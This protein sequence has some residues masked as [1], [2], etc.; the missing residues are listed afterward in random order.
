MAIVQ[1][2]KAEREGSKLF[3]VFSAW[4]GKGKTYTAVQFGYGLAGYDASK[5]GLLDAENKRGSLLA[6]IL[7]KAV[8]KPTKDRFLIG[9]LYAPFSPAR[10][11]GAIDDFQAAGVEVLIIDSATHEWEGIGGCQEIAEEGN[12]KIPRWD[13]AKRE[14]KK[15][16]NKLLQS[17]MHIICC[18]RAREKVRPEKKANGKTEFVDYGLQPIQEK[19]FMFEATASLM[20]FDEGRRQEIIKCPDALINYLGRKEG[21]ITDADGYAVRQWVN[22]ALKLDPT[23]E[24]YRNRLIS[25]TEGGLEHIRSCWKMTPQHIQDALGKDFVAMLEAS[26]KGY[27]EQKAIAEQEGGGADPGEGGQREQAQADAIADKA[28]TGGAA[29]PATE[30][31]ASQTQPTVSPGVSNGAGLPPEQTQPKSAEKPAEQPKAS[32]PATEKPK[33]QAPVQQKLGAPVTGVLPGDPVF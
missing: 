20:M 5:V 9:D 16:M 28:R 11:A 7:E 21:Y 18:V 33:E 13:L 32:P 27:D 17:D 24:K 10:Y 30:M 29:P 31:Q 25:N 19:N 1:I 8:T 14:H 3:F 26:A 22:G 4:T 23:V 2:R 6:D 15:F 12:P